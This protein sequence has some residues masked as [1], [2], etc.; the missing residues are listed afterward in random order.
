[1]VR[2]AAASILFFVLILLASSP[3]RA[4]DVVA[5]LNALDDG[6]A[7]VV[8]RLTDDASL[9]LEDGRT[10]KLT[11]LRIPDAEPWHGRALTLLKEEIVGQTVQLRFDLRQ[12]DRYGHS[13]AQVVLKDGSWVQEELVTHGLAEVESFGDDRT[14]IPALL[15]T[16]ARA[17]A[18]KTGLWRDPYYAVVSAD[19]IA[20]DPK[21]HLGRFGIVE[22]RAVSVAE[23]SN[24]SFV[25]F[26]TDWHTDFTIA[27]AAGDRKVLRAGGLDL[28]SL[29]G[30]KLRVR[31]WIRDWNG[32]L[33][34]V[35]HAEQIEHLAE[36]E[37]FAETSR[38]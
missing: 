29:G 18:A 4:G 6:G 33:I 31:G 14:M 5:L 28:A 26:G 9:V 12:H 25:N 19:A 8:S 32:P 2:T 23:R 15:E 20:K 10:V 27:V 1:M 22:G 11:G 36:P 38:P 7:A 37:A 35:T 3:T 24:W 16:E 30:A 34:E 21:P 13:L 17:R